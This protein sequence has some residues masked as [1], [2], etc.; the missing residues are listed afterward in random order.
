MKQDFR[1]DLHMHTN[2]SDGTDAPLDLLDLVKKAHLSGF[3]ITD[4]DTI[5]A[6]SPEL[7]AKAAE[8]GLQVLQGVEISSELN[9]TTVHI[10][11]YAF[12]GA[13]AEFLDKVV[14]RRKKRNRRIL[15][16]LKA[17]GISID[18]SELG[19][20]GPTQVIGRPHIAQA[21]LRHKAV[22]S[23]QQAYDLYLKDDAS[24]YAPG[25]KFS[26]QEVIDAIHLAKGKAVLAHPHFFKQGR[27]VKELLKLPFDGLECYYGLLPKEREKPWV[28]I[29]SQKGILATGGSDYHGEARSASPLGCSWVD[30]ATF[31]KLAP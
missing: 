14:D 6:Y 11:G 31:R 19:S 18:E 21:M 5:Q 8:L 25:G 9:G 7:F 20:A 1:A 22:S 30:E 4:H 29:A 24:C 3:S 23:I 10:L 12:D 13:I 26:P 28:A 16:K 2:C 15:E 17:K 27:L